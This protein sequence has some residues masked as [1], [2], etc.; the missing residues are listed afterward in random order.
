MASLPLHRAVRLGLSIVVQL[1]GIPLKL[2]MNRKLFSL[3]KKH[4]QQGTF[5]EETLNFVEECSVTPGVV[6]NNVG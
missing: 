5:V 1:C 2:F 3:P 4:G 6:G